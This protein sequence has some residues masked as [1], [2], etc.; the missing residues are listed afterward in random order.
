MHLR[1]EQ[2]T[3]H[4]QSTVCI[5]TH[6]IPRLESNVTHNVPLF[7]SNSHPLT[8]SRQALTDGSPGLTRHAHD[9]HLH[10]LAPLQISVSQF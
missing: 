5:V 7:P 1:Y 6:R 9:R 4:V 8:W 3:V 2:R 10:S